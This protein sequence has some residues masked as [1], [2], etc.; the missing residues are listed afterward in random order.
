MEEEIIE[1]LLA[2][3]FITVVAQAT[4]TDIVFAVAIW[5]GTERD[6]IPVLKR[7]ML[8]KHEM[9]EKGRCA[10]AH[11]LA[12]VFP[13]GDEV[14]LAQ[15]GV[16]SGDRNVLPRRQPVSDFRE[17]LLLLNGGVA[18]CIRRTDLK[19]SQL[20][21]RSKDR[22]GNLKTHNVVEHEMIRW[23]LVTREAD[24]Q[25]PTFELTN[26]SS[27]SM[28]TL[29]PMLLMR[30]MNAW[31]SRRTLSRLVA[32]TKGPVHRTH[33]TALSATYSSNCLLSGLG[34]RWD[35][36]ARRRWPAWRGW[37]AWRRCSMRISLETVYLYSASLWVC[38]GAQSFS[39]LS[40]HA[41]WRLHPRSTS[42]TRTSST[43]W[44]AC[45]SWKPSES[46]ANFSCRKW[47][48]GTVLRGGRG[49]RKW[50]GEESRT[51]IVNFRLGDAVC[52]Q[53][54]SMDDDELF[55]CKVPDKVDVDGR[56]LLDPGREQLDI[57]MARSHPV[58]GDKQLAVIF[59][60]MRIW[61][62]GKMG[63]S[64]SILLERWKRAKPFF[65]F[66]FVALGSDL[67]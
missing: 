56:E 12:A 58:R 51:L 52:H 67:G 4:S 34:N 28:A 45:T 8:E 3:V 26:L 42:F 16:E 9:D 40:N 36:P 46:S 10:E 31:S 30:Y 35:I 2:L 47:G 23:H 54:L 29:Q 32:G 33:C 25:V 57:L 60:R 18:P 65:S 59:A 64:W 53:G 61:G 24:R 55:S 66:P 1:A 27:L 7:V 38:G 17:A 63:R 48:L 39:W 44:T 50:K 6:A 5:G 41:I 37:P 49:R 15:E 22:S 14:V 19:R 21:R 13:G 20:P 43:A 11:L 62:R